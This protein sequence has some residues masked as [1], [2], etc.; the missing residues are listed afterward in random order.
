[1]ASTVAA[2][3]RCRSPSSFPVTPGVTPGVVVV[4]DTTP[5]SYPRLPASLPV[6]S[7]LPRANGVVVPT[8]TFF[9]VVVVFHHA[10]DSDPDPDSDSFE[11][12]SAILARVS[13]AGSASML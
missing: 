10:N 1:M 8:T 12:S 4:V 13:A 9:F 2:L 11:A 6:S 7:L 3:P 5:S